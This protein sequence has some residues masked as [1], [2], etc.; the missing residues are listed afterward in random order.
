MT[1]INNYLKG[2]DFKNSQARNILPILIK[3]AELGQ[4]LT[5]TQLAEKI[6]YGT[7]RIFGPVL[8]HLGETL[9]EIGKEYGLKIPPIQC[10]VIDK[11]NGIPGKGI[12]FLS[13]PNKFKLLN[14]EQ[15]KNIIEKAIFEISTFKKWDYILEILKIKPIEDKFENEI[16]KAKENREGKGESEEHKNLKTY[17][18]NNPEILALKF[19]VNKSEIEYRLSSGDKID[20]ML[21]SHNKLIGIEVKSNKSSD[22]D[23]TRGIFQCIKYKAVLSAEQ[24]LSNKESVDCL[25][26]CESKMNENN[27]YIANLLD[28]RVLELLNIDR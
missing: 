14:K 19:K 9:K 11:K 3:R 25:L 28:V 5:Y 2:N 20:V 24:F 10:I 27:K 17:I 15:K 1:K 8:G 4:P 21:F 26:I 6:G 22:T 16:I 7:P 18:A 13:D 23:H 12:G